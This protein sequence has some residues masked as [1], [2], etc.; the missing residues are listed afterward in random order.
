MAPHTMNEKKIDDLVENVTLNVFNAGTKRTNY[1]IIKLLPTNVD[2]IMKETG[3]TKV[4]VNQRLN[5]L[6]KFGLLK[7]EKGT[8]RVYPTDLTDHFKLLINKIEINVKDNLSKML[9]NLIN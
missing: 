1:K 9:P 4:P 6:E 7:R 2:S 5:E 8:G 3:L